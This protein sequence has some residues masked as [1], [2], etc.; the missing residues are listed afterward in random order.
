M[1]P[2]QVLSHSVQSLHG[3]QRTTHSPKEQ[4]TKRMA[5]PSQPGPPT[6]PPRQVRSSLTTPAPHVTEQRPA[7]T[8]SV[9]MPMHTGPVH[10][11]GSL[12]MPSQP[13]PPSLPP[14]QVR[15]LDMRPGPQV[16]E[17]S[18]QSCHS[19]Q[20]PGHGTTGQGPSCSV[21]TPSA[22]GRHGVVSRFRHTRVRVRMPMPQ[23][24]AQAFHSDHWLKPDEIR[25]Q[26]RQFNVIC[27]L[28]LRLTLD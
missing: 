24:T 20:T 12:F 23:E 8:Q 5:R 6:L 19:D 16:V 15:F 26:T 9:H 22:S 27:R 7:G 3:D 18:D 28:F 25:R 14:R 17:H 21:R 2:L 11:A 4:S 13:G 10:G 1:P